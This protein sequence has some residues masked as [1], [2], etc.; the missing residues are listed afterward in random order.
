MY[1]QVS[2]QTVSNS[3]SISVYN[4]NYYTQHSENVHIHLQ[5]VLLFSLYRNIIFIR[6]VSDNDAFISF[7]YYIFGR[8]I[9]SVVFIR[10]RFYH[11]S[12][13]SG[14]NTA[15]NE[16]K[17]NSRNIVCCAFCI[18]C[19]KVLLVECLLIDCVL[20]THSLLYCV[21]FFLSFVILFPFD[22]NIKPTRK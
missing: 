10:R 1:T 20:G 13:F 7:L 21:V 15:G 8:N 16:R 22:A 5:Y 17:C 14:A 12:L 18:C 19:M 9:I 2:C 11:F 6:G 4:L 3:V